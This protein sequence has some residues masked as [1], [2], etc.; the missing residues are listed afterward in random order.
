MYY[1]RYRILPRVLRDVSSV[2]TSATLLGHKV[3]FPIGVSPTGLHFAVDPDAEVA[4]GKGQCR[5]KSDYLYMI[6]Y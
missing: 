2:D 4:T 1:Y 5:D 3:P 6:H